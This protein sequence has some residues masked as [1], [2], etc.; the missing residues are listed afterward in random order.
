MC[1]NLSY[2][3]RIPMVIWEQSQRVMEGLEVKC[4][5]EPGTQVVEVDQHAEAMPLWWN[6]IRSQVF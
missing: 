5:G 2:K 1:Q 6:L 3:M 4:L